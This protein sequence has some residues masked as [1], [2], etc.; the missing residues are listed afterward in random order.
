[1]R[2]NKRI[3]VLSVG[4]GLVL[5]CILSGC[6]RQGELVPF[7][8]VSPE[9]GTESTRN[10]VE[11]FSKET[12]ASSKEKGNSL[13]QTEESS[14]ETEESLGE[15]GD[16]SQT[17]SS[18]GVLVRE[19]AS[20]GVKTGKEDCIQV[21]VCGAVNTPGVYALPSG[22]RVNDA[23]EAAGGFTEHAAVT[24]INLAQKLADE[25]MI[26]IFTLEELK[27][28]KEA[29]GTETLTYIPADLRK[30]VAG[31][32]RTTEEP[33]LININTADIYSLCRLPGIGESKARDIVT[34]R[35]KNGTFRKKE[36]IM[37]VTGIKESLYQRISDLISVK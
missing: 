21:Y 17:S 26:Y 20:G 3:Q 27:Q 29:G 10:S 37:K 35:E 15:N 25:Q 2:G 9:A 13:K 11:D 30:G 34:Y 31:E 36:D 12:A 1:M 7:S 8:A 33:Q 14:K 19:S 32:S 5:A 22:S 16:S 18:A 6:D 28:A 23:V 24:S 4:I